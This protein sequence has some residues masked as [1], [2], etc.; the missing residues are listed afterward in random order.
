M[1]AQTQAEL[2]TSIS[3]HWLE[4]E[5]DKINAS[6]KQISLRSQNLMTQQTLLASRVSRQTITDRRGQIDE[7]SIVT[8]QQIR[9]LNQ[10]KH[11][12]L[13]H[14]VRARLE[15]LDKDAAAIP[16][17]VDER[18]KADDRLYKTLEDNLCDV[19]TSA[20]I[21]ELSSRVRELITLLQS[22]RSSALR[23]RL[24]RVYYETLQSMAFNSLAPTDAVEMTVNLKQ[25]IESLY[26]EIDDVVAMAIGNEHSNQLQMQLSDIDQRQEQTRGQTMTDVR[27]SR[28]S[29]DDC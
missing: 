23:D 12:E 16:V 29:T 5:I 26:T 15:V 2:P 7:R 4:R 6:T 18:L 25:D 28:Y 22:R 19:S 3:D 9:L 20:N 27:V 14:D 13:N 11:D 10:A 21:T 17:A 1:T 24:D 8:T